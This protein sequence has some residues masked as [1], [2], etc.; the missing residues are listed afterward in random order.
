[1]RVCPNCHHKNPHGATVCE[2]CQYL[3]T[4][5]PPFKSGSAAPSAR[6]RAGPDSPTRR[7]RPPGP[8][9][10]RHR[11][12]KAAIIGG[13]ALA[14]LVPAA[15]GIGYLGAYS[16]LGHALHQIDPNALITHNGVQPVTVTKTRTIIKKVVVSTPSKTRSPSADPTTS[17]LPSPSPASPSSPSLPSSSSPSPSREVFSAAQWQ[18]LIGLAEDS[19]VRITTYT[20]VLATA[21]V[22][23]SGFF[24]DGYLITCNHV[25]DNAHYVIDVWLHG[26]AG[27]YHAHVVVTDPAADLAV[28]QLDNAYDPGNLPLGNMS[29]QLDGEPV[30]VLGHPGGASLYLTPGTLTHRNAT[31]TVENYGTLSPMLT[32]NLAA[33]GGDSGGPVF[34]TQGHVIG[35]LEDGT[36]GVAANGG[37]VPV[38]TLQQFLQMAGLASAN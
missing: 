36:V 23:G 9:R 33:I 30:A 16:Q 20:N 22:A 25:I 28:L 26:G 2:R 17:A 8:T 27:P 37:A 1:M 18:A 15:Y 5:P 3:L 13:A 4:G 38:S 24:A 10:P 12:L 32:M 35:V 7:T 14:I 21:E 29:N 19:V 6:Q 11:A 34:D 31:I